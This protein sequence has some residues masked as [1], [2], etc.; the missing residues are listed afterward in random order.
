MGPLSAEHLRVV[1]ASD[2]TVD[3]SRYHT[4]AGCMSVSDSASVNPKPRMLDQMHLQM[5]PKVC[6]TRRLLVFVRDPAGA[7]TSVA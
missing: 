6:T 1:H 7:L 2:D 4:G 3:T 5:Q